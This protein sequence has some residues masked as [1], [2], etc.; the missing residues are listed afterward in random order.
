MNLIFT[1]FIY[2]PFCLGNFKARK[3]C[4]HL[5]TKGFWEIKCCNHVVTKER[6]QI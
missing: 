4:I 2:I 1:D 5:V 6:R 3:E